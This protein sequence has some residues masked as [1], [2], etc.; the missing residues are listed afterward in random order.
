MP[1]VV[2]E[3]LGEPG[4]PLEPATR[5]QL[6]PA[7]ARAFAGRRTA[8]PVADAGPGLSRPGDVWE[9]EAE[10]IA[11][12]VVPERRAAATTLRAD[13]AYDF[14]RVRVHT[15]AR[16]ADSARALDAL[17]YTA[18]EHVVF[19]DGRY[20]PRTASGLRLLAHELAH[21]VQQRRGA[22]QS[23][24]RLYRQAATP[25]TSG[26][27]DTML[28][29]IARQL[30]AAMAGW[31]TDE[32]A[33]YSALAGR[34]QQQVDE[35]ARVYQQLY[36][37]SL[38]DDLQDELSE[39]ELQHLAIFS[40][41]AAPGSEATAAE[42]ARGLADVV[43]LQLH[44]AMSGVGTDED[45]I[46]SALTG[47]TE[48]ERQSIRD[49]YQRLTKRALEADLNDELSG[50]DLIAALALLRQGVLEPEDEIKLAVEGLG[51]D[52]SRLFAALTQISGSRVTIASTI[53][54]YAA[55][56]YGD[57]LADIRS[58]LSFSD[59]DRAMELLHGLT[60]S[61]SCS[62]GQRED[63]LEAISVATSMG[64]NAISRLNGDIARGALSG[65]VS[66]ALRNNF[67]P[68]GAPNAVNVGLARQVVPILAT[69]LNELRM[70]SRINCGVTR[71]CVA[72][73]DCSSFTA[74]HTLPQSRATVQLCPA[75]FQC[76]AD[77]GT[78]M[79]HE[80]VHHTGIREQRP[81]GVYHGSG[82]FSKLVPLGNGSRTDSLGNADAFAHLAKDLF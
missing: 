38:I 76:S 29:Q 12:R 74:A 48:V 41:G 40:P 47:R 2:A 21:V 49:A 56:G 55:K 81:Q 16:A 19:G 53:D 67:N 71:Q 7:V 6:E 51:T 80:F 79:L 26:L 32:E 65:D 42:H 23:A 3:V 1:P 22:P 39:S 58:D 75:F 70:V 14:S 64:Q 77:Q 61:G 54:R 36:G 24:S 31:G 45:A 5:A 28:R 33:I 10:Q 35:I 60:P 46:I 25:V 68:G 50:T 13:H 63:G 82:D 15:G 4:R 37:R 27:T 78:T 69:A 57:M 34:T 9:R 18:G 52:E 17:A 62:P 20:A 44:R 73:P 59:F 30:R 11:A 72:N 8:P 66:E 43:A